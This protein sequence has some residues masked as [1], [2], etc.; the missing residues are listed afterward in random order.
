MG[1][2]HAEWRGSTGQRVE[3]V[4]ETVDDHE[5]RITSL[6]RFKYIMIGGLIVL[7]IMSGAGGLGSLV[8]IL[9]GG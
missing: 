7:S 5:D 9:A 6:E 4:E 1:T 2:D 8:T 3:D